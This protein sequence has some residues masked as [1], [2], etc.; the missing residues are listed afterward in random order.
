M[1]YVRSAVCAMVVV[2]VSA[3]ASAQVTWDGCVDALGRP[4]ASVRD[5]SINDVAIAST[6]VRG[7]IIR[8]N[9]MVLASI[10]STSRLFWYL[11]ECAHHALGHTLSVQRLGVEREADCWAARKLVELKGLTPERLRNLAREFAGNPGDWTHLPGP[12]RTLDVVNCARMASGGENSEGDF[13][14]APRRCRVQP[15]EH[16][17]HFAG[18]HS[19]CDHQMH[20][21]GDVVPCQ[22]LC[23]NPYGPYA[24]PLPCHQ[25]DLVPCSHAAHPRGD[26]F[27]CVHPAHPAGDRVCE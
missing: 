19:P 26:L 16:Q 27:P 18:D 12:M 13:A 24:P 15:C 14:P 2:A 7:P 21:A 5:L 23:P 9:P 10:S 1:I 11:H 4:V 3:P 22:H 20:P 25:A 8:Y 17:A 6:T